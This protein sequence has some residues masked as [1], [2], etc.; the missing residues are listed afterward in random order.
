MVLKVNVVGALHL[1]AV[2]G[3]SC[4]GNVEPVVVI[5][6]HTFFLLDQSILSGGLTS[7]LVAA[8][9]V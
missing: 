6:R 8:I 5:I 9:V 2:H 1:E 3:I 4:L 7:Q